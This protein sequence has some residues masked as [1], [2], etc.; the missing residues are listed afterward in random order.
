MPC[1]AKQRHMVNVTTD[2]NHSSPLDGAT[3][4]RMDVQTEGAQAF[5]PTSCCATSGKRSQI[6]SLSSVL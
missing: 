4:H 6:I 1:E 3:P 2:N 5:H